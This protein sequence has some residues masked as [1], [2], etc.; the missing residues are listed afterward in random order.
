M[1]HSF[2]TLQ[3]TGWQAAVELIAASWK[4]NKERPLDYTQSFIQSL[5]DYPAAL[6][7][8]APAFYLGERL[9]AFVIGFPRK[10]LL[11]GAPKSLL[12][13]TFFTVAPEFKGQGLG[14]QIWATCLEQAREAGYDGALYY[15]VEGNLSNKVTRA[16]VRLA[17]NEPVHI[18]TVKYLMRGLR[19]SEPVS[20]IEPAEPDFFLACASAMQEV[21]LQRLWSRAEVQWQLG[22]PGA[23]SVAE[24]AVGLITGY[25]IQVAD[26]QR[27]TVLF[28]EDIFWLTEDR[29]ARSALVAR[30]MKQASQI[31]SLAAVPILGCV[32]LEPFSA[33]GFRKSPRVLN[34]YLAAGQNTPATGGMESI[35]ADVL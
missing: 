34:C 8:I 9:A 31:A 1:T 33:A 19:P 7:V 14:R 6:P 2:K 15:C 24:P 4:E 23:I 10:F 35:Y 3:L 32:D 22:R 25:T 11:N 16:G 26:A 30:L 18:F 27:T 20:P 13:M 21:P 5:A 17:G 12:L 29:G 28:V